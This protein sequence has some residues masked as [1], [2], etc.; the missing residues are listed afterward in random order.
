MAQT[1]KRYVVAAA[2]A[3][4]FHIDGGYAVIDL[5]P[6]A[7]DPGRVVALCPT[8]AHANMIAGRLNTQ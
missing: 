3:G 1:Y 5:E 4:V 6:F 8:P 2:P 7:D